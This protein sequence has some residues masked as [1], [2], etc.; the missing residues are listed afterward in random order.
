MNTLSPQIHPVLDQFQGH[1]L[2]TAFFFLLSV[3]VAITNC[4]IMGVINKNNFVTVGSSISGSQVSLGS[5]EMSP[6]GLHIYIVTVFSHGLSLCPCVAS[7][8][9]V[10]DH[11]EVYNVANLKIRPFPGLLYLQF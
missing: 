8:I 10:E 1:L 11:F 2:L 7:K 3:N 4:I 9:V 5:G 6:A